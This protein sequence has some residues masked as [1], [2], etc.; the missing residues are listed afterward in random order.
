LNAQLPRQANNTR[1]ALEEIRETF[2]LLDDWEDRYR[3]II[4]LGKG[5]PELPIAEKTEQHIVHGCQS[6]VWIVH[7]IDEAGHLRLTLDS[8]ALIVRGLIAI[9][10]AALDDRAPAELLG[11][12]VDALFDELALKRHL[13]PTRGN[14]LSAMVRRIREVARQMS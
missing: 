13:S 8:D 4:E 11:Y 2:A 5:L 6:Q 12:D 14:G 10:L 1:P 3:F 9:V 7:R